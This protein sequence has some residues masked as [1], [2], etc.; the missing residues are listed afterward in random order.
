LSLFRLFAFVIGKKSRKDIAKKNRETW[1]D[2]MLARKCH[3]IARFNTEEE[4]RSR[5][6]GRVTAP[7]IAGGIG[8][9]ARVI[10]AGGLR[11]AQA[12]R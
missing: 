6:G 7:S 8:A 2:E 11:V 4:D 10:A 9:V 3:S 1:T 5:I 12:K